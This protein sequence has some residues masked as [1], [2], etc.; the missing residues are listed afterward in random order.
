MLPRMPDESLG[1]YQLARTA[2]LDRAHAAI[3]KVFLPLRL[4]LRR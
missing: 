1:R 2:D 4:R 3:K